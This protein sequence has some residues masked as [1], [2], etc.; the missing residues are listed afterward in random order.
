MRAASGSF[1][2][3]DPAQVAEVGPAAAILY[4]RIVWRAERGGWRASRATMATETGLSAWQLRASLGVLRDR[5]L[6]TSKRASTDDATLVWT[7]TP[8]VEDSSVSADGGFLSH[9]DVEDSSVTSLETVLDLETPAATAS[10]A[11]YSEVT[12]TEP[13]RPS[14]QMTLLP[15]AVPE[16]DGA[17]P[18]TAQTMVAR[19]CDG[20]RDANRGQ[21]APGPMMRRVA[22]QARNLVKGCTTDADWSAAWQAAY[23]AGQ[24]GHAD[25]VPY[26]VRTQPRYQS[27]R[28]NHDLANLRNGGPGTS[29]ALALL[30]PVAQ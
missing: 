7:P 26:L 24:H 21:D 9:P 25:A 4:A 14:E 30:G 15:M 17:P 20:Y 3:V 19:W 29:S 6:V 23:T 1:M 12:M 27:G 13:L 28:V 18:K 5:G 16:P 8:H 11:H 10:A 2:R 22:G